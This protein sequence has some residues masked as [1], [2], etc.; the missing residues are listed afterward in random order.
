MPLSPFRQFICWLPAFRWF[1]WVTVCQPTQQHLL[2]KPADNSVRA[3]NPLIEETESPGLQHRSEARA[4]ID[5][6]CCFAID[7]LQNPASRYSAFVEPGDRTT[8]T[9]ESRVTPSHDQRLPQ[10]PTYHL[11]DHNCGVTLMNI[12]IAPSNIKK[13]A[14]LMLS[15]YAPMSGW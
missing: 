11:A 7:E 10:L 14:D 5:E 15:C 12:G 2:S 8:T 13:I 9:G 3:Y 6:F 1:I 4:Y